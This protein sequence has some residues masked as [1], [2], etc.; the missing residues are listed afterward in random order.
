MRLQLHFKA[1]VHKCERSHYHHLQCFAVMM[2]YFTAACPNPRLGYRLQKIWLFQL[3]S[4]T[5]PAK[6][7]HYENSPNGLAEISVRGTCGDALSTYLRVNI[8]L[9]LPL[10][11][12][13]PILTKVC[14]NLYHYIL[15]AIAGADNSLHTR[16]TI[17]IQQF[18]TH[19]IE[20]W[21]LDDFWNS[22]H[23]F[24]LARLRYF[25]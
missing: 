11:T 5:I 4:E 18:S 19:A 24:L 21:R 1:F 13:S 3:N 25:F 15:S 6:S 17:K 22:E 8:S 23:N 16:L 14:A 7:T 10:H 9:F 20:W 12:Y 2:S